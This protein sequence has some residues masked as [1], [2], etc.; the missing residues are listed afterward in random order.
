MC[1]GALLLA[2]A[3]LLE[4]RR[5]TTHWAHHRFLDRLGATY[6][7]ERWVDDGRHLTGAGVA[8]KLTNDDVARMVQRGMDAHPSAGLTRR[9]RAMPGPERAWLETSTP[10]VGMLGALRDR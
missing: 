10:G 4:G 3:G 6:A 5:A 9:E 7:P 1:T 8:A 2:G